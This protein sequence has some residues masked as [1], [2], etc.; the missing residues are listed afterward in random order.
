[1]T[2]IAVEESAVLMNSRVPFATDDDVSR[3][4]RWQQQQRTH[5]FMS[6]ST[7]VNVDIRLL[8]AIGITP[9]E[10]IAFFP[11]HLKWKE[12]SYRL[13]RSNWSPSQIVAYLNYSRQLTGDGAETETRYREFRKKAT[14]LTE[15]SL[16]GHK[17]A[18]QQS[19]GEDAVT[20]Q[21]WTF[22]N[23][24]GLDSRPIDYYLVDLAEGVVNMPTGNGAWLLTYSIRY[25]VEHSLDYVK[26]SQIHDFI[27]T[28]NIVPPQDSAMNKANIRAQWIDTVVKSDL[29]KATPPGLNW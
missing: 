2:A 27:R 16:M 25:A 13:A 14:K 11:N 4:F 1:M 17:E 23:L 28:Y 3:Y 29:A 18:A 19:F 21:Q 15:G 12:P 24:T 9:T 22:P 6:F 5:P 8:G 10:I 20:A 7:P 26:L